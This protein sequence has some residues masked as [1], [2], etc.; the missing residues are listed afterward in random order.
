MKHHSQSRSS[1]A[2][3]TLIELLVVI[4]IILI[5]ASIIFV[6]GRGGS[7]AAL[8]SS[9]RIAKGLVDGAR[10]Q[11]VLKNAEVA[12]IIYAGGDLNSGP[13][14]DP[15][16]FLRFFGSVQREV[17]EDGVESWRPLNRGT[18]LPRGVYF[19]PER[20]EDASQ[21]W[22]VGVERGDFDFPGGGSDPETFYMFRFGSNGT[23][24]G[25]TANA[26][27]VLQ[28]GILQPGTGGALDIDFSR[29]EDAFLLSALIMRPSGSATLVSDP[30]EVIERAP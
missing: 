15:D 19:N 29:D 10:G 18:Y 22:T 7:G 24:L 30:E 14:A 6:A 16:K 8:S 23:P 27:L 2:G 20:S 17:D 1:G 11:A 28:A 3:F 26:W 4:S 12:L 25:A 9:T 13:N 5:A 21:T